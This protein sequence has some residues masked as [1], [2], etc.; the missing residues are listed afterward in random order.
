MA[1]GLWCAVSALMIAI[2]VITFNM[3]KPAGFF[4]N[5]PAPSKVTDITAYNHA[6]GKLWIAYGVLLMASGLPLL[7]EKP[8]ALVIITMLGTVFS[9]LALICIYAAVIAPK[10][11]AE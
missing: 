5:S 8:G 9:T 6:L 4:A 11:K 2:G 1:F 3:K 10:Y 7:K